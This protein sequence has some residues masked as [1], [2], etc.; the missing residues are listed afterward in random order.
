MKRNL[1]VSVLLAMVALVYGN[2]LG[3]GF[4]MDDELYIFRNPQVTNTSVQNL[5]QPN[6]ASGVFRPVTFATLSANWALGHEHPI[7][8]HLFNLLLHA[9]VTLLLFLLLRALLEQKPRGDT[10]AFTASLLF[11]VHPIHTEA[12]AST[13]GRSELLAAGFLIGAWLLHVRNRPMLSGICFV[14]ALLSK[15]SAIVFLPMAVAG[16][17]AS[18]RLKSWVRYLPLAGITMAYL[19]VLWKLKGGHL[20]VTSVSLLDN[21]LFRLPLL[22]RILNA[23][24]IAWKYA[25]LLI[26]PGKLS[27]DYSFDEIQLYGDLRH[28]LPATAAAIGVV[29]AWVWSI[30]QR[31]APLI[32]AGAIYLAGFAVTANILVP[33]GTIMGERLAY[34]PSAGFCLL[35]AM[36]WSLVEIR[37]RNAAFV[38]MAV[39]LFAFA[40]RTVLRNRDWRDDLSLYSA[41]VKTAPGSAKMHAYLGNEYLHRGQFDQARREFQVALNTY[42]EFPDAIEWMALL[43]SYTGNN[44]EA[45][46]L[47]EN[48]LGMVDRTNINYDYMAVNLAA[49]MMQ[50]GHSSDALS[51]L[52][53]EIAQS[54]AY[55]RAWSNRAVI[56][57]QR[58]ELTGARSDA[59][60]ALRLDSRNSQAQGVLQRMNA[61][62][63]AT[64]VP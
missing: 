7:G 60:T 24:R 63:P 41:A 53:R 12:V 11:A 46:R 23:I 37:K 58:G 50:T 62:Q 36:L 1:Q 34:L 13:I 35:L 25:G 21:P 59:E 55:S 14:L 9:G 39:V 61:T 27:C 28:T 33:T 31:N 8:Y 54:P 6:T 3:N 5:F 45:L 15:E 44:L 40:A 57:Y 17:Y 32:M 30:W 51:L 48:A 22:L 42:P 38:V 29:A 43:E 18:G 26:F 52:D 49:M 4:T 47:M 2:S 20:G 56:Y 64:I 10:I 16:D 19:G